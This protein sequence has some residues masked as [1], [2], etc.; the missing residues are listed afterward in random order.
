[1]KG[2]ISAVTL[3]I[4]LAFSSNIFAGENKM[5]ISNKDKAVALL[6]SIETGDQTAVGYVNAEKYTQHNLSVGDGLAGFGEV[7]QALPKDSAKVKVVRSFEDGDYVFTHT[8]Y[9]FF[10]PKVGFDLFRFN[11]G[12]IVEHWDNLDVKAEKPNPSGHTQIDGTTK[13]SDID[14]TEVNKALV[15][16]FVETILMKGE[17]DKIANFID[18][19]NYI[20]HNVA[21]ADGLSGLGQALEA[22]AKQGIK[23]VYTKNYKVLG[24]GNF[25]LSISE[26]QFGGKDTSFYDLFRVE[27]GKI[28]EHWDIIESII[29]KDQWKNTNG[30]FGNL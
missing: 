20:Q 2:T 16:N 10:G 21:I 12:L 18:G 27:N 29:P 6:N 14:K 7:L 23:M 17:M 15:K 5:S 25:V 19:E 3:M 1:M 8:D 4:C 13:V 30:K 26:G 11:D 22:M 9:N 24:E 28:V